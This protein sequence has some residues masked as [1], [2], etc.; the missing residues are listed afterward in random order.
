MYKVDYLDYMNF[1]SAAAAVDCGK[2]YPLS[3]AEGIQQGDIFTLLSKNR[4]TALFWCHCG[5]AYV[6][7]V[8]D[9][10]FLN[11]I[12][13]LMTNINSPRRFLLMTKDV[14]IEDYFRTKTDVIIDKRYLFEYSEK[15]CPGG[16]KLPE[17]YEIK[18]IDKDLLSG[19]SGKIVPSLFWHDLDSF[20][21]KGKGYCI[22][23]GG[24]I[25]SW[26]FSASVG[27]RE[28]DI[29]IETNER[30]KRKGLGLIAAERMVQYCIEQGIKP[31]WACHS[32]NTASMKMSEKLGF[33]LESECSVIKLIS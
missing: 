4:E 14:N 7:G 27:G 25:A 17:G 8:A 20:L 12:Y 31:V 23:Y 3:V 28:I 1:I 10:G 29:G 26:A 16:F 2:V 15:A 22:T 32:Q 13:S 9:E 6:S 33:I 18:E 19:I 21:Q 5:F 11:E 24:D 30:Y